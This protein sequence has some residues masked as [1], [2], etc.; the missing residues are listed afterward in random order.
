[1]SQDAGLGRGTESPYLDIL[2]HLGI[3]F[4][5]NAPM[6][7]SD[8]EMR[9]IGPDSTIRRL[10]AEWSTLEAVLQTKYGKST[11]ATGA[12]RQ[13]R[14]RK[15]NELRAAK[16]RRRR[17]AA[18]LLRKDHFKKRNITELDRQLRG[19]RAPQQPLQ[20]VVF[21]LP[22]RRLL[23]EI[24]GD[25]DE[26]LP[27]TEIVQRKIDAVNAWIDYAWKIEPREPAPSQNHRAVRMPLT[28][29]TKQVEGSQSVLEI[30]MS[31]STMAPKPRY[32][33]MIQNPVSPAASMRPGTAGQEP[34]P[35]YSEVDMAQSSGAVMLGGC[36]TD[37]SSAPRKPTHKPHKCF[38]CGRRFTRK[39]NRWNCEERH[40]KR[41]RTE[42]VPCPSPDCKAKGI[43]LE[44][45]LRFK[46]HAKSIHNHDMRPKVTADVPRD[47]LGDDSDGPRGDPLASPHEVW[48]DPGLFKAASGSE[49]SFIPSQDRSSFLELE[50]DPWLLPVFKPADTYMEDCAPATTTAS[51]AMPVEDLAVSE[52]P[53]LISRVPD[54]T[55]PDTTWSPLQFCDYF[56]DPLI[57]ACVAV[58]IEGSES[59]AS[60]DVGNCLEPA[61]TDGAALSGPASPQ[62]SAQVNQS[63][64]LHPFPKTNPM[65][66]IDPAILEE[67]WD[68]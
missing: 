60:D 28:E 14:E 63:P 36:E 39:G 27:E 48:E 18:D 59:P 3:Q 40:L 15:A 46:N 51:L 65:E 11:K 22:E 67:P 50:E 66:Y 45:E 55:G 41:R 64:G 30:P 52:C 8:E 20:K 43:V 25:L 61:L 6:G 37:T 10:E 68:G 1:M 57:N 19:I 47:H 34:P 24:L 54:L 21:S 29:G 26:D 16:Q 44:N 53:S 23:A 42:A 12:D 56:V 31:G 17:K 4:D 5:E 33:S 13:M 62:S 38:F 2:N 9:V 35:P 49:D 7:V 32:V 58:S